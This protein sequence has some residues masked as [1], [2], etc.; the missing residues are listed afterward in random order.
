MMRPCQIKKQQHNA[1]IVVLKNLIVDC[2]GRGGLHS[3]LQAYLQ[4]LLRGPVPAIVGYP[5]VDRNMQAESCGKS[6]CVG[7]Y[8]TNKPYKW[9]Y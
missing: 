8:W 4:Q 5:S 7:L 3:K 6:F 2:E 9:S 1:K